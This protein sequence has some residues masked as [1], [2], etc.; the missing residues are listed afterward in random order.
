MD[1]VKSVQNYFAKMVSDVSGMKVLLLDAETTP[2]ISIV[3][4]QSQLLAK[5]IY[6]IDKV[7][8]RH[9]EKMRHLKCLCFV[10][11]SPESIQA[12]VE[13]L[14][15]PA[16]GEYYLYFSNTLKKSSVERLAEVDEQEVVREVQEFFADF[17]AANSDLFSL[18]MSAPAY[19]LYVE[20]L[21]TWDTRSFARA[22]EG[23]VSVLLALKKKP[24]IRY[25]RNS[26]VAKKLASEVMYNIQQEGPLFEFRRTDTPP[27]LLILD[28][29]NDPVTPLLIPWTYQAM[30]H[31]LMGIVNGRVDL[32]NVPD[33]RSELKEV[34]LSTD[35]DEFYKSTMF[36]NMGDLGA[37]IKDY[38][39]DFQAKHKSSMQID[40]IADMKRFVEQYPDFRKLSG[41]VTKHVT[42]VGELSRLVDKQSLLEV[43]ELEQNLAVADNHNQ[44]LKSLLKLIEK[45]SVPEIRKAILAA[46]YA[47]R[48]E[49]SPT[50]SIPTILEALSKSGVSDR[51]V[52]AVSWIVQY[53]GVDQRQEGLFSS[54]NV[55]N[56]AKTIIKGLKGVENVYTQHQPALVS[57]IEALIKG[58]LKDSS[59]PFIDSST[60]DRPQDIIVF[61]IGG[62]TY[63]EA[64]EIT[65][66]NDANNP[67]VRIVLGGTTV[68]N[69][70]SFVREVIDSM[71][72]TGGG[73][74]D[75]NPRSPLSSRLKSSTLQ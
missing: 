44:D 33:V 30:V 27:V 71:A 45:P 35:Q 67:S 6:L 47:L 25:Q 11:P 32:S 48:Y 9:R 1:L 34:V 74:K 15:E 40:S 7:E 14:R 42:L 36:L 23:L 57:T 38:V 54:E 24:V 53:A 56:R 58:R 61:I 37:Q 16:Y 50:N 55:V 41:N 13:E 29:K 39:T 10:R 62:V 51:A 64:R 2:I 72:R 8:N 69:S 31:E 59:Y 26:A 17:H 5:E 19:P 60:R 65:K 66:L 49:K 63:A 52:S 68:H 3:M 21:S 43:S 73:S 22:T 18:N 70:S 12:V 20:N 28:R 4:T 75:F 46:L